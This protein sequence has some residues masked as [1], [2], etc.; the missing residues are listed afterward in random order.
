MEPGIHRIDRPLFATWLIESDR[1]AG[2]DEPVLT[3]FS[4]VL[5]QERGRIIS[6]LNESG[7]WDV[8]DY[9]IQQIAQFKA[10]GEEFKMQHKDV[11]I[12][13]MTFEEF[14]ADL[15][16]R[17]PPEQRLEGLSVEDILKFLKQELSP[18]ER[19]RIRES[20]ESEEQDS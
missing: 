1:I 17:M 6:E 11:A 7:H 16:R 18:Q 12:M 3:L 8:V 4:R 20:L 19:A 15:L 10:L 5:L 9:A 13:D 14:K 2:P